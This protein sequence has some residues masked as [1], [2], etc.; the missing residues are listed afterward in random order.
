MR[1]SLLL[2]LAACGQV[3]PNAASDGWAGGSD[4]ASDQLVPSG[5]LPPPGDFELD[6]SVLAPGQPLTFT[7]TNG[8]PNQTIYVL[9]SFDGVGNGP[10]PPQLA[11][12]CLGIRPA[13][14]LVPG[15]FTTNAS[16]QGTRTLNMPNVLPTDIAFQA[17]SP[18]TDE[19]SNV[20]GTYVFP[21]GTSIDPTLD[22]DGDTLSVADGDCNDNDAAVYPGAPDTAGDFVDSNCDGFDGE[23]S[24]SDGF[25]SVASGGTDCNDASAA[26]FPGNTEVCDGIDNSCDG[27]VD[28][29]GGTNLCLDNATLAKATLCSGGGRTSDGQNSMV[30]CTA[31]VDAAP[32]GPSTDG[33]N[34]LRTGSV[35][36]TTP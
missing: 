28:S 18:G 3:T 32:G 35:Q 12:K 31:P 15:S 29:V 24:D 25:L 20:I 21:A 1:L 26:A 4:W 19:V 23:D 27:N 6:V 14:R 8:P 36:L 34:T 11:T 5:Q 22:R 17:A 7:V 13:A 16:G 30:N 33:V 10:C 9:Y 2:L